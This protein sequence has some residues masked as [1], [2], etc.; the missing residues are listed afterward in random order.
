MDKHHCRRIGAR[1]RYSV[2][3]VASNTQSVS[4][5]G[6]IYIKGIP[7]SVTQAA[8]AGSSGIAA[9]FGTIDTPLNGASGVTGSIGVTG[10][11]LDDAGVTA[12]RIY[13][14]PV[15]G[16]TAGTKVFV[17][18][19][20][21]VWGSARYRRRVPGIPLQWSSRVGLSDVDQH[22]AE[23][24]GWHFYVFDLRR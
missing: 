4:R 3:S 11:A 22:V 9:P 7:F 10:W 17:G 13:R 16:E 2:L 6:H 23:P 8:G 14:E 15:A 12:I 1:G 19:A 5:T 21:F 18:N 20:V 24:R